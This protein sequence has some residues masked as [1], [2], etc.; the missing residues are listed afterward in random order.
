[1]GRP[2][3]P[4]L[5]ESVINATIE[6][7]AERGVEGATIDAIAARAGVG[8][9]SIYRRWESRDELIADVLVRVTDRA[10]PVPD[11]GSLRAD[12]VAMLTDF[13]ALMSDA[14]GQASI[15]LSAYAVS[16]PEWGA[17]TPPMEIRRRSTKVVIERAI[18]RGE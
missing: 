15:A 10:I 14:L 7:L 12:L 5:A 2:R 13:I 16:H 8:K 1:M 17:E 6:L 4:F 3:A 18:A 9:P 11:T